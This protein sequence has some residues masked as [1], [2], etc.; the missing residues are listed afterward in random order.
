M[1]VYSQAP[2]PKILA[3]AFDSHAIKNDRLTH[4][5]KMY[6]SARSPIEAAVATLVCVIAMLAIS[7]SAQQNNIRL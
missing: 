6:D 7:T 1:C 3:L 2:A 4:R 5:R